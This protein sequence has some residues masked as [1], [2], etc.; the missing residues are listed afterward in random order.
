MAVNHGSRPGVL[1]RIPAPEAAPAEFLVGPDHPERQPERQAE[2]RHHGPAAHGPQPAVVQVPGD[3]RGD[4]EGKRNGH[5][6]EAQVHRGRVDGHVEVLEQRIQA[7]AGPRR[8]GEIGRKRVVVRDHQEQEEHLH[9]AQR[10][11]DVRDELPMPFLVDPHGR[12]A[13]QR[14]QEH[15][16]HDRAVEAAPVG[17][18]L[19]AERLR[20]LGIALHVLDGE[21]ADHERVDDDA[22]GHRHQRRHQIQRADAALD[23]A[24]VAAAGTDH[25]G[26]RRVGGDDKRRQEQDCAECGHGRISE[27]TDVGRGWRAPD[28]RPTRCPTWRP[29]SPHPGP[30]C[31]PALRTSRGTWP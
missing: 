22:G 1:D 13:E 24:G 21:V 15:P 5:P 9:D 23:Q 11:H 29:A 20:A 7:G 17:R 26:G 28:T 16:E 25:G 6:D 27:R 3:E 2:P 4:A 19:V 8:V 10:R 14:Q 12:R 30:W 31:R 18:Q